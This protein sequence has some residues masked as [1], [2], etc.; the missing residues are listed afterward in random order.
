MDEKQ[1]IDAYLA[2]MQACGLTDYATPALAS[3]F[4][5]LTERL[6][7]FDAHT[8]LTAVREPHEILYKHYADSLRVAAFLPQGAKVL[9]VGCG[10]GFPCLPLAIARPDLTVTALDSTAKKLVFVAET[11]TAMGLSVTTCPGRAEELS[12]EGQPMRDHYDCVVA[13]AVAAL[14]VLTELCLPFVRVGGM[15]F[16]MKGAKAE[17]ELAAA[18]GGIGKLGAR[19]VARHAVDLPP[20]ASWWAE[21]DALP[22][23]RTILAIKKVD[24]TP[25]G[26]PRNYGRIKK[27]PL[28]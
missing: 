6:L 7:A 11:A 2:C 19:I 18:K 16:A 21:G 17:E 27:H 26:L 5:E 28:A 13:R 3:R 22:Q 15:F 23:E 25:K 1:F 10:G 14:P 9:D 12:A 8:N 20:A 24:P 4:W